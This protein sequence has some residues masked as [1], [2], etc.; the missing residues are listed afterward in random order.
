MS[1]LDAL[2]CESENVRVCA[3]G[4]CC[5]QRRIYQREETGTIRHTKTECLVLF[6]VD[7]YEILFH[8]I[9]PAWC[10]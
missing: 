10:L 3:Q 6:H 1:L 8:A 2:F 4:C 9:H 7:K 5:N